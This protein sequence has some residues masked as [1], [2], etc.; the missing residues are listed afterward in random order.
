MAKCIGFVA[1]NH[2]FCFFLRYRNKEK[3]LGIVYCG[4]IRGFV[5]TMSV[6]VRFS[7]LK[8]VL[9]FVL[10]TAVQPVH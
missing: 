2:E 10:A 9:P 4:Q 6:N 8:H 1:L 7:C 5:V 3:N